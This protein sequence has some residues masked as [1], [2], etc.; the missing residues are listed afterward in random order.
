MWRRLS[1]SHLGPL[2]TWGSCPQHDL[3][4]CPLTCTI[5]VAQGS[6]PTA[7]S[8][9]P[10]RWLPVGFFIFSPSPQRAHNLTRL[11]P[12]FTFITNSFC[13]HCMW[14]Q[15]LASLSMRSNYLVETYS[16]FML[17]PHPLRDRVS[18]NLGGCSQ[19]WPWPSD[20][21]CLSFPR[22]RIS[23]VHHHIQLCIWV[24]IYPYSLTELKSE[25]LVLSYFISNRPLTRLYFKEQFLF[26]K[27]IPIL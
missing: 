11:T 8:Q 10:S 24:I 19:G 15:V 12:Q 9:D 22:D 16:S 2:C 27:Q 21:H 20:L 25:L 1:F 13:L 6:F 17:T 4:P 7:C 26:F 5:C 18:W 23:G 14:L 3:L